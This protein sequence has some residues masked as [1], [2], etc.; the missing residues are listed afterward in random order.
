MNNIRTF[1]W[2]L[3]THLLKSTIQLFVG[4]YLMRLIAPGIFGQ[5]AMVTTIAA[6]LELFKSVGTDTSLVHQR[7][8]SKTEVSSIFWFNAGIGLALGGLLLLASPLITGFYHETSLF[9]ITCWYAISF[10]LGGFNSVPLALMQKRLQFKALFF[11]EAGTLVLSSLVSIGLAWGGMPVESLLSRT[12]FGV[13][14]PLICFGFIF[15]SEF[16]FCFEK[17]SLKPHL[18]FGLPLLG[19]SLLNYGVRNLDNLLIGRYLGKTALG[20]YS[21]SYSLLLF[22]LTTFSSALSRVILPVFAAKQDELPYVKQTYLHTTRSLA[23]VTFP[24]M[25]F[26]FISAPELVRTLLGAQWSDMVPI[27]RVFSILGAAQ[28][29]GTL[30]GAVYQALGYTRLQFKVG[31]WIK[32]FMI[33]M[34]IAGFLAYGTILAIAIFYAFSSI[35]AVFIGWHYLGSIFGASLSQMLINLLPPIILAL[36]SGFFL[37][38]MGLQDYLTGIPLLIGELVAILFIYFITGLLLFPLVIKEFLGT[39]KS[40]LWK[41]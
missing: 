29:I 19:D 15:R 25:V 14:F 11:L 22:P 9:T 40:F 28:S 17:A 30:D 38:F 16:G 4:I 23:F 21:R 18:R 3:C 41:N 6:F 33:A 24:L 27:L 13:M 32:L 10:L 35:L 34:I 7:L 37:H 2:S 8:V 31:A 5:V 36:F 1:K 39:A 26:L 20:T 12:L